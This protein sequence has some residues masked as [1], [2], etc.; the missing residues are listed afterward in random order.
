MDIVITKNSFRSLVDD[1][2]VDLIC[3]DFVQCAST[4]RVHALTIAAQNKAQSYIE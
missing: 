4:T 1:V 2:I 3:I